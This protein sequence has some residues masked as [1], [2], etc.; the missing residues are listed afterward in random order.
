MAFHKLPPLQ[1]ERILNM[2]YLKKILL[3]FEKISDFCNLTMGYCG[4]CNECNK[5]LYSYISISKNVMI[6]KDCYKKYKKEK[7]GK[8]RSILNWFKKLL[9]KISKNQEKIGITK[10]KTEPKIEKIFHKK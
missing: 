1:K 4:F 10:E 7:E 9:P 8:I 3:F 6:C 5:P 2:Q